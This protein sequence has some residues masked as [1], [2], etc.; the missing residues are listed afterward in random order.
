M[1]KEGLYNSEYAEAQAR[2]ISAEYQQIVRNFLQQFPYTSKILEVGSGRGA[3]LDF[4]SSVGYKKVFGIDSS[5]SALRF[6][7]EHGF[8]IPTSAATI[9][10]LPFDDVTFDAGISIHTLEHTIG[11]NTVISDLTNNL[12]EVFRVT[13]K[14]GRGLHIYPNPWI[15]RQEGALI[16]A[17]QIIGI[18]GAPAIEVPQRLLRAWDLAGHLHPHRITR[19]NIMEALT[20]TQ[21]DFVSLRSLYVPAEKGRSWVLELRK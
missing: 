5:L 18:N 10:S 8:T 21:W 11:N 9:S 4:I 14:G 7:Q 3:M 19:Q 15:F 1:S 12:D 2:P 17:I 16:D 20:H 13:K 6:A